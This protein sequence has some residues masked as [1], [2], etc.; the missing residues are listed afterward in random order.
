MANRNKGLDVARGM[1][2]F[3][4][5]TIIHGVYWLGIFESNFSSLLLFEMPLIFMISGYAY[6]ITVKRKHIRDL[7][8]YFEYAQSR[9]IRIYIPYLAYAFVCALIVILIQE[10]D[11]TV[12]TVLSW[13]NPVTRGKGHSWSALT[14]HLWFI[15]PF[16]IVTLCLPMVNFAW[17]KKIPLW[18]SFLLLFIFLY[19]ANTVVGS[20]LS[21]PLFYFFW[22][23]LGF[24]LGS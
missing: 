6:A 7:Y 24:K 19:L 4:I 22:A 20:K 18:F 3:Y 13:I 12:D 23:Y 21:T 15:P 2:M 5:I 17:V 14:W 1:V 16:L 11:N 9:V 8:D 10:M